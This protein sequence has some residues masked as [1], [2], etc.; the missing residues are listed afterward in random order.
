MPPLLDTGLLESSSVV[1][2]AAM[3]R[4]RNL[5]GPNSY[6]RDLGFDVKGFLNERLEKQQRVAWLDLC[7]GTG[8][9]LIQAAKVFEQEETSSRI[10]IVGVDLAG[11]FASCSS[12]LRSLRLVEAS[13][14]VLRAQEEFDLIT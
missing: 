7:C 13:L 6:S 10:T 3:N 8:K 12:S 5:A 2:N 9:A 11:M 4:E 14:S 1:A